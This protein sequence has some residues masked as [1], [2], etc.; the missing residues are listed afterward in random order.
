VS[1]S[2]DKTVKCWE[3]STGRC[4]SSLKFSEKVTFVS[5]IPISS[6]HLVAVIR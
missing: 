1:G 2:D 3:I 4:L 6:L 5:W